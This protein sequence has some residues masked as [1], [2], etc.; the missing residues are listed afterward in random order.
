M[1]SSTLELADSPA[2]RVEH[3]LR[4]W[5]AGFA[6]PAFAFLAAGVP[7]SAAKVSAVFAE[8]IGQGIV[9]G[10]VGGKLIGVFLGAYLT[11]RLTRATLSKDLSWLDVGAVALVAG[12]GFTV[13]LLITELAFEGDEAA[14]EQAT[15]AVLVASVIAALLASVVLYARGRAYQR[16]EAE[17]AAAEAAE[18]AGSGPPPTLP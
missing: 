1:T 11:A 10:L 2:E 8:P 7:L 13:S 16:I 12:V 15:T 18:A 3:Q 14:L 4:P 17:D 9:V 6:V 5:S